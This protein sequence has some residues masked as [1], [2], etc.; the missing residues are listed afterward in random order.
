MS[1]AIN[2]LNDIICQNSSCS[3]NVSTFFS[4]FALNNTEAA[5]KHVVRLFELLGN[6]EEK[7]SLIET[8]LSFFALTGD[9]DTA[10]IHIVRFLEAV[11]NP[12][13]KLVKITSNK[14]NIKLIAR[15]FS[16]SI[17]FSNIIINNPEYFFDLIKKDFGKVKTREQM[18]E[19]MIKSSEKY[20]ELS[21]ERI[22][23]MRRYKNRAVV[24]IGANDLIGVSNLQTTTGEISNLADVCLE[25][26]TMHYKKVLAQK[27][28]QIDN[29][30]AFAII[31]MGKLGGFELNYSSDIDIIFVC[32]GKGNTSKTGITYVEYYTMLA[33]KITEAVGANSANGYCFRVDTR[34]RP[35]GSKGRLVPTL[36]Y[37]RAYYETRGKTWE[38]QALIKAR[39]SAGNVKLG[40]KFM[41]LITPFVYR[42]YLSLNDIKA[43]KHL[44]S[45][46]ESR[47]TKE[48]NWETEVKLGQGGIRDIEFMVQFLQ[49]LNGG[50][51]PELRTQNTLIAL[52][53][54]YDAGALSFEEMN[55]LEQAYIFLRNIEHKLQIWNYQQ[56]H[57][58]PTDF[59][60][61]EKIAIRMGYISQKN[62]SAGEIFAKEYKETTDKVRKIFK[63]NF[64]DLFTSAPGKDLY[65]VILNEDYNSEEIKSVF[66]EMGF[67]QPI[68]VYKILHKFTR[69]PDKIS[70]FFSGMLYDL[71]K[72][73]STTPDPDMGLINFVKILESYK[74]YKTLFEIFSK[75]KETLKLFVKLCAYSQFLTDIVIRNPGIL[76]LFTEPGVFRGT[77]TRLEIQT[78][79]NNMI[80]FEIPF[81]EAIHTLRNMENF[82][83]GLR[84][85]EGICDIRTTNL[86]L[87]NLA[88]IIILSTFK[89]FKEELEAKKGKCK[90][91]WAFIFLGK[92]GGRE[93]GFGGDI[94]AFFVYD[95]NEEISQGYYA[96]EFFALVINKTIRF[97]EKITP[98]GKLYEVDFRLRPAGSQS[99]ICISLPAMEK[100][101]HKKGEVWERLYLTKAHIVASSGD[102]KRR[103]RKIIEDF[104]YSRIK[105]SVLK[106][107][108]VKMRKKIAENVKVEK[109][110]K[111][112]LSFKKWYGGLLDIEFLAECLV[113]LHGRKNKILRRKYNTIS[114]LNALNRQGIITNE[115]K[116]IA[117][118]AYIFL[119]KV[120]NI[121]RVVHNYS[122]DYIPEDE[123]EIKLL[124]H[125][126]NMQGQTRNDFLQKY[127]EYSFMIRELYFN[128]LGG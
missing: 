53:R 46:I 2:Y 33:K 30:C 18:L 70:T 19:E 124:L 55:F 58:L 105:E 83:I 27:H 44:K 115:E 72:E 113:I 41:D 122:Y 87:T 77:K 94:D 118:Q 12:A 98:M 61:L 120:E 97:L 123:K 95:K 114:M 64:H 6:D 121:L 32:E 86:E 96:N 104:V 37:F 75:N 71:L 49:L 109:P 128:Y 57:N 51:F 31:S 54:L 73:L 106:S 56:V 25:F 42:K 39:P 59:I 74:A 108:T 16:E 82:R 110:G 1:E 24:R 20:N 93:L 21:E 66:T 100:H 101:Y 17:Y 90:T 88:H 5:I 13:E 23:E 117:T 60:Q 28:G 79:L 67:S 3:V 85:I 26:S 34:L 99:P 127:N 126:L 7:I 119:R 50:N 11:E 69:G 48:G 89:H 103:V 9:P 43:I 125:R 62:A 102:F 92:M 107:E 22:E 80:S 116:D 112:H 76:D 65:S 78:V 10:L 8:V 35:E 36:D 111:M 40:H 91:A 84:N 52:T 63:T 15:F 4:E 68:K 14:Q 45:I 38:R 29:S 81:E 47:V